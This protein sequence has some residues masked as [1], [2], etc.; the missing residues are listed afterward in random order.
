MV[1]IVLL[2]GGIDSV[3]LLYLKQRDGAHLHALFA[4]YG[5][6]AA[7]E[8]WRAAQYHANCLDVPLTRLDL[9]AVG[10]TFRAGQTQ[11][12]HVPLPHRN[13][14]ALALGLSFAAQMG[15]QRIHLALNRDDVTAYPSASQSFL[16]SFN[17]MA[18]SLG[19]FV[20]Q[21]PLLALDK[22][23]VIQQALALGIDLSQTYSC[24][25]GYPKACGHCPQCVHRG[26]A[27]GAAG[28]SGEGK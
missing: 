12:L 14:V 18:R 15:A 21:T 9:A 8:E 1:E 4:D 20:V 24:L 3:T 7:G 23:Q 19:E 5:Q 28:L 13:L 27:L 26:A 17:T 11:R 2:S 16:D 22:I 6:R 10:E 25:L